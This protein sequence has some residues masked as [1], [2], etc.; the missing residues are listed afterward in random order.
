MT[1]I[2]ILYRKHTE[3]LNFVY[4]LNMLPQIIEC[5]NKKHTKPI[6]FQDGMNKTEHTIMSTYKHK[7]YM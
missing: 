1:S 4:K 3:I 7:L 2:Y 5:F 6:Q